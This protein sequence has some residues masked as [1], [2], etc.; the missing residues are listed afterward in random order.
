[1]ESARASK[2]RSRRVERRIGRCP[3]LHSIPSRRGRRDGARKRYR[4][5]ESL[6]NSLTL[7][8][9]SIVK[10]FPSDVKRSWTVIEAFT[11][12]GRAVYGADEVAEER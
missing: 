7:L 3:Y 4:P 11:W 6:D 2:H 1:M 8:T 5:Q 10:P 9:C 12:P